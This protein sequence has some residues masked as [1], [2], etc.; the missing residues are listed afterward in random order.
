MRNPLYTLRTVPLCS[1][2]KNHDQ[3]TTR[4]FTCTFV[5]FLGVSMKPKQKTRQTAASSSSHIKKK[6][7]SARCRH[8]EAEAEAHSKLQIASPPLLPSSI[9]SG[10]VH[11]RTLLCT[12]FQRQIASCDIPCCCFRRRSIQQHCCLDACNSIVASCTLTLH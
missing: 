9:V 4:H 12:P 8:V 11:A 10:V 3:R 5:L 7:P 2:R 1:Y 6:T